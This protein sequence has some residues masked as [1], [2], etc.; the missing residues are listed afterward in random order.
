MTTFAWRLITDDLLPAS[1]SSVLSSSSI[2]IRRSDLTENQILQLKGIFLHY[3]ADRD[4]LLLVDQLSDALQSIGFSN[5]NKFL[6]KFMSNINQQKIQGKFINSTDSKL[7]FK[8]DFKTFIQVIGKEVESL[9]TLETELSTLF[10]FVDV[11][12]TGYL[13]RRELKF[14]LVDVMSPTRLSSTEFTKFMKSLKNLFDTDDNISIEK[15]KQQLILY[16]H[17]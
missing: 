1:S 13:S 14:L 6:V 5:R 16:Y 12:K 11:N 9:K 8:T 2:S 17:S 4:G 10:N 15:L 3:D 7:T